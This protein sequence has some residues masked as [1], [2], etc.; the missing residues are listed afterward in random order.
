MVILLVISAAAYSLTYI[1]CLHGR[2]PEKYELWSLNAQ[3]VC[4]VHPFAQ[5]KLFDD[6]TE[7]AFRTNLFNSRRCR[8]P[9][10]V[11]KLLNSSVEFIRFADFISDS[12]SNIISTRNIFIHPWDN[13]PTLIGPTCSN[14][15]CQV[16]VLITCQKG[17]NQ[18]C[19]YRD[20]LYAC[21]GGVI[22][23][24]LIPQ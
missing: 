19:D 18:R 8:I 14:Y 24:P 21:S 20:Y 23:P 11:Q 7:D 5:V 12:T 13:Y 10:I 1:V 15:N 9:F 2:V 3:G 17:F 4:K 16:Y 22:I 6:F